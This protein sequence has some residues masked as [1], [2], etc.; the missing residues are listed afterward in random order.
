M[1][2]SSAALFSFVGNHR[3]HFISIYPGAVVHPCRGQYLQSMGMEPETNPD[4]REI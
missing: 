3:L 1:G 4:G 2:A